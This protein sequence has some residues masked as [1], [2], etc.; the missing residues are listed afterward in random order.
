MQHPHRQH[1]TYRHALGAL[2]LGVS[3]AFGSAQAGP[4]A[5]DHTAAQQASASN[6]A[7]LAA[8]QR[9][10][11]TFINQ[12]LQQRAGSPLADF[13]LD[14]KDV[15]EL[16][17][18]R[19][20]YGFPVYTIDPDKILGAKG[21]MK[22]MARHAN[23][24]RFVVMAGERPVGM[25]TVERQNGRFETVAYGAAVLSKDLDRLVAQHGNADRSNLRL[26]RIYQARSDLLEVSGVGGSA[27]FAPLLSARTSLSMAKG[28]VNDAKAVAPLLD[29]AEI[30]PALRVAVKGNLDQHR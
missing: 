25:A 4:Q 30:L 18:A 20:G 23:Q 27:R 14:V 22:D 1:L 9:D 13:P 16:K 19:I 26:V 28:T 3:L 6:G 15:S 29:D 2:A 7:A 11:S 12:L 24:W 10:L 5:A 21:K 8:A 17:D